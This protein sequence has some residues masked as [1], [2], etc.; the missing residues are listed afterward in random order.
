MRR[1][2]EELTGRD[3]GRTMTETAQ[4]KSCPSTWLRTTDSVVSG[5]KLLNRCESRMAWIWRSTSY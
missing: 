5:A 3:C 2:G 4:K 1:E